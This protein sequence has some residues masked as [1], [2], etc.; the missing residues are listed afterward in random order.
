MSAVVVCENLV[1][2]YGVPGQEVTALRGV[3][4]A[5]EAGETVA[6]L[7]PSGSGKSTLLWLMAGLLAPTAGRVLV[8]G[9]RT[10]DLSIAA[11]ANLRLREVGVILQNPAR[12]L[13]PY[14]SALDNVLFASG[15]TRRSGR[16]KRVR[17]AALL[18]AVGLG[19]SARQAAG[20]LSGGEQ[21]R[22]AMAVALA[23][24]PRL[25]LAD[26][27]TSQLDRESA[28]AVVDLLR[29]ANS[30]LGTTVVAVTHD[31][32]VGSAFGRTITIRD[33]RVGSHSHE[34]EEYLVVGRDGTVSLPPD[35]LER[36][37]PGSLA[38]AVVLAD[39]VELR[40]SGPEAGP[41]Q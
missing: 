6:L 7:G 31:P 17:A 23:N 32:V 16:V 35:V 24:G 4:L 39:G 14:R 21:Q 13:L 20:R 38:R 29:S 1:Q 18:D 15:P 36:L 11:A 10:T 26:E 5:V 12:N 33:G 22:L 40:R 3:D 19:S 2:V 28:A 9:Q 25:L 41:D 37:P 30:D 27:P 34:G 8:F